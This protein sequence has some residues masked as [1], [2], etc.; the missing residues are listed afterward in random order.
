MKVGDH[1]DKLIKFDEATSLVSKGSFCSY[2]HRN[3]FGKAMISMFQ[4]WR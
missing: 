3:L 2:V 4:L 1:I